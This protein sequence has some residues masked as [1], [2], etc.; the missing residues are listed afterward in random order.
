MLSIEE[1]ILPLL[2][3]DG[4]ETCTV[5]QVLVRRLE[6][7]FRVC[8]SADGERDDLSEISVAEA[9]EM[10]INDESGRFRPLKSS[11]DLRRGWIT[12]ADSTTRLVEVLEAVHPG[13]VLDALALSE[14]RV[15]PVT[16]K[17]FSGRQTGMYRIT[18]MLDEAQATTMA[19]AHC[20]SRFCTKDR[21]WTVA[22]HEA[23]SN[24][25]SSLYPCLE[26]C[27]M[28]MEFARKSMRIEQS[29][30]KVQLKICPDDVETLKTALQHLANLET[31][32]IDRVADYGNPANPRRA[33]R[34]LLIL[35]Q[36]T[37]ETDATSQS[38]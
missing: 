23:N 38:E 17:E 36:I 10:A 22:E 25:P 28:L 15:A 20:N 34:A 12:I 13:A 24:S 26:P 7:K 35:E 11:P 3:P 31:D 9:R 27:P 1:R 5:G 4:A 6:K 19:T 33:Q 8:H 29:E 18:A 21:L 37:A 30:E 32:T 16:Y 14:K 2:F